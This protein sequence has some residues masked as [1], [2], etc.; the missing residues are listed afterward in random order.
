MWWLV[1]GMAAIT[2][3]L[4]VY[5]WR[6]R[7][8]AMDDAGP[9]DL[10]A[11]G[12]GVFDAVA[13]RDFVSFQKLYVNPYRLEAEPFRKGFQ[14]IC[15]RVQREAR[16]EGLLVEQNGRTFLRISL[17]TGTMHEIQ[18]GKAVKVKNAY[19]LDDPVKG[20]RSNRDPGTMDL[21]TA[22]PVVFKMDRSGATPQPNGDRRSEGG[23]KDVSE[24]A[25]RERP[26]D[27][28]DAGRRGTK[29]R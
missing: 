2:I 18:I 16:Y 3:G 10:G 8:P 28:S 17:P 5:A 14:R 21:P 4:A 29:R 15:G 13:R 23:R 27:A 20:G 12:M 24:P 6:F 19:K 9:P 7:R 1:G 22:R 25:G 26:S 11:L